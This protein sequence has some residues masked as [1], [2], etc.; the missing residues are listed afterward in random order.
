MRDLAVYAVRSQ[1]WPVLLLLR[2][3]KWREARSVGTIEISKD[4][5]RWVYPGSYEKD[6]KT[7][8]FRTVN[9]F[10][11]KMKWSGGPNRLPTAA[12]L[13]RR[14]VAAKKRGASDRTWLAVS[15]N[16][17]DL[18]ASRLQQPKIPSRLVHVPG[19]LLAQRF[20]RRKLHLRP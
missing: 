1:D 7:I 4:G 8:Q 14:P 13:G 5:D 9:Q 19:D 10:H 6:G 3:A 20:H 17:P 15:L 11:G 16:H 18:L 12:R 2:H